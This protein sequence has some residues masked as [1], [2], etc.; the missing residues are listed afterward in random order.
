MDRKT[1]AIWDGLIVIKRVHLCNWYSGDI[2]LS[3]MSI[4]T[5][6][7]DSTYAACEALA[8]AHHTTTAHC[9][10]PPPSLT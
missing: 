2:I 5:A 10:T 7:A 9:L 6:K 8:Y 1:R 4:G 3:E